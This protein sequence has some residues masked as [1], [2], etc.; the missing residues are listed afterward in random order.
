MRILLIDPP[1]ALNEVGGKRKNFKGLLNKIPSL[2]LAY[3]AATAE[4]DGH[5]VKIIDCSIGEHGKQLIEEVGRFNPQVVGVTATTP[6]FRNA[7]AIARALRKVVPE[8]VFICGGAHVTV[9]PEESL[10]DGAFDFLVLGEGEETFRE[11][12]SYLG[13]KSDIQIDDIKGIAFKRNGRK[14]ITEKRPRIDNLDA[15]P[16]PARHLFPSFKEYRPTP[17]SY[18]Y[19]PLAIV[20]TSR[21]CPS[22]CTFCD[23]GVFGETFRQR[24]IPH[25]MAEIEE[26]TSKYGAKEIRFFDDTFT[27]TPSFVTALCRE[28]S[29]RKPVIPWTCLTKVSS[30]TYEMLTMMRD[31]GCWQV[32]FGLE[33]G[34]EYVLSQ[35]SKGNTVEQNRRAVNWAKRA[36]LSVRADFLA[37]S[38]WETK[39]S[40]HKTIEFAK[41]LSLDFAHFNKFV[42]YPGTAIYKDLISKGYN[43]DFSEGSYINDHSR[44]VYMP[45]GYRESEYTALLNSAYREF[46]L[47][48]SYL[49]RRL[50]S[51]RTLPELIGHFRGLCSIVSL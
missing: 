2:G 24:S 29:K 35:L 15:L 12:V 22:R 7:S 48:L 42:P 51:I 28:M 20:M 34:D 1:Y 26:V 41:S 13:Y 44:F 31:A 49:A 50:V 36:G 6:T 4:Q 39:K 43:F 10:I 14:V 18:R 9:S 45:G 38:P 19:L 8:A 23:R 40:F 37:G 46:Y 21:G 16:F 30:V 11:L 5:S 17:A 25:V 27:V 47:R 32:L 33:S 3:L